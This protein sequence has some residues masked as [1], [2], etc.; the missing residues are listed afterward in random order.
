VAIY[1]LQKWIATRFALA[2][3]LPGGLQKTARHE[4]TA[5]RIKADLDR[6]AAFVGLHTSGS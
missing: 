1:P 4:K 5:H 2:M 3:T 6:H